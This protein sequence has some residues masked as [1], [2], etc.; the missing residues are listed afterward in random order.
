MSDWVTNIIRF[1]DTGRQ[2]L[3]NLTVQYKDELQFQCVYLEPSWILNQPYISC[4][5]EGIYPLE[6]RTS[7]KFGEHFHIKDVP[8]RSLMLMHVLNY[9]KQSEG[10]GGPGERFKYLDGDNEYDVTNSKNTLKKLWK[11]LPEKSV[12]KIERHEHYQRWCG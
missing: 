9:Y 8:N 3:S 1:R 6:K 5:P 7:E 11:L 2:N 4:A 12:I 10:C